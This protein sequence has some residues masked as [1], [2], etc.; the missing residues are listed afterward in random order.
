M[1]G[2]SPTYYLVVYTSDQQFLHIFLMFSELTAYKKKP[3]EAGSGSFC[4][5]AF[6][7]LSSD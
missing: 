5:E 7:A 1:L 2:C 3:A 6:P 4:Y